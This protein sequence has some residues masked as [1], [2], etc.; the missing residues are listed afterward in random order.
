[1]STY[2]SMEVRFWIGQLLSYLRNRTCIAYKLT[3]PELGVLV[4]ASCKAVD[5]SLSMGGER[6]GEV[7]EM[8][9][10]IQRSINRRTRRM[11]EEVCIELL[12][13]PEPDYGEW[14]RAMQHTALRGG[15]WVVNDLETAL[16]HLHRT[17]REM[18]PRSLEAEDHATLIRRHPLAIDLIRYWISEDY[19]SLRQSYG[20]TA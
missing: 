20:S 18:S 6:E 17:D 9:R 14:A 15:L 2:S 4:R 7:V 19:N 10:L 3:G 16:G 8:A 5:P 13:G 11:L 12:A 1:M